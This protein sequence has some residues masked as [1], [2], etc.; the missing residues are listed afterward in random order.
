VSELKPVPTDVIFRVNSFLEEQRAE[1]EKYT[2]RGHLDQSATWSLHA[3]A[4]DI[5][6]AGWSDGY[7]ASA[8][9]ERGAPRKDAL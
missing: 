1:V 4:R 6:A 9:A 3:L 5:Y 8:A 7:I 2:N